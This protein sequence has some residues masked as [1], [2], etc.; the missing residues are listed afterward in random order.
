MHYYRRKTLKVKVQKRQTY[1]LAR[2]PSEKPAKPRELPAESQR[3][4]LASRSLRELEKLRADALALERDLATSI[5]QACP[6]LR[7]S[8]RNFIHY[9]ALRQHDIRELQ[10]DL[11]NLGASS[12]GRLEAHVL[13]SLNA[14]IALLT[15]IDGKAP[16]ES[17]DP[18]CSIEAGSQALARHADRIL[19]GCP[20]GRTVRIMVTMPSEAAADPAI[21]CEM[22][23]QGMNIM[24]INCAHD[25]PAEWAGMI[26]HLR[27]AEKAL[28]RRCLISFDLAGPKLRTGSIKPATGVVRWRP[29]RDRLGRTVSAARIVLT[30]VPVD[31]SAD[32][33]TPANPD[34]AV[35]IVPVSLRLVEKA[36]AGDTIE[37]RDARGR[38]RK[39]RVIDVSDRHCTAEA[40]QTAYVVS[41]TPLTL[42]RGRQVLAEGAVGDLPEMPDSI[43][44]RCGDMLE[45]FEGDEAGEAA[46]C[47]KNGK[48]ITRARVSCCL[49]QVFR[50]ARI[51]ERVFLDDGRISGLIQAKTRGRLVVKV[52]NVTGRIA[53]LGGEK[54][55]NLPDTDLKL[56]ALTAKDRNDLDFVARNA[57]IVAM[58]FVQRPDDLDD[59]MRELRRR[60][61]PQLPIVLKIETRAAFSR[62]PALLISA[63]RFPAV[64]VMVA[65][66]DLG[67]EVGFERLSEVQEEMLWI[68]EAAHVPVVWATQVL[69][70]LAK[71]GMPTRAEVTDAAVGS[72]A[73][74]VML[75]K[76][77]YILDTL[78]FL[79]DVIG[80][81]QE[82]Q[83]K[84]TP[85]LRRLKVSDLHLP[86]QETH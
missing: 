22:V 23:R 3:R 76:G 47:D 64:A 27:T 45:I 49:P 63:M 79:G 83:S 24:R 60:N 44:L 19:G 51:G 56:P 36:R 11:I 46:V 81:M 32:E 12:L 37:L 57:D 72:R 78:R 85:L 13:A 35:S 15:K 6:E 67:V 69:E 31:A 21:I 34:S 50:H 40:T 17:P 70:S 86:A 28:G 58:S 14:V 1:R 82:H 65:R 54:G 84:K 77:P 9:L 8:L 20:S 16:A 59:L 7:A 66:G 18:P 10:S 33:I 48:V 71:G 2:K 75:N 39:L 52:T 30:G 73:E 61:V 5:D 4:R 53:K 29:L 42:R 26:K 62:L 41:N 55:I 38:E 25:S 43:R 68:C 74:C 80:R